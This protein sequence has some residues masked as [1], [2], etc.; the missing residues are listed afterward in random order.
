M[1]VTDGHR[2][3]TVLH[4]LADGQ[5]AV[6]RANRQAAT[7]QRHARLSDAPAIGRQ[8]VGID[9][10]LR[11]LAQYQ[12]NASAVRHRLEHEEAALQQVTDI[13]A[14]ATELAT[15][16]AGS[17]ANAA[18]RAATAAEVSQLRQQVIQLGNL[19]VGGEFLFGGHA[20]GAPPFLS[21]GA[22]IGTATSRQIEL[23][24]GQ[25][26]DTVHS[27]Q[28]MLVDSGVLAALEALETALLADDAPGILASL[29]PLD[30]AFQG[31][32]MLLA[33]VGGRDQALTLVSESL[34]ARAD[35]LMTRRSGL[36][37]IS[38]EEAVL[39]L[40]SAQTALEAAYLTTSRT[41]SL[42]LAEYLR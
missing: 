41:L 13:L 14:R 7:G 27:G 19:Q 25:L 28:Q 29:A 40:S 3:Q 9:S 24:A 21:T 33:E 12:R 32:Q 26:T 2:H 10:A 38:L 37:D 31:V 5:E 39:N 17:T 36:S 23:G 20:T 11:A 15:G 8:V 1:R 34:T 4:R 18:T 42:T 6:F 22:Y 16:Q 30:G 35:S